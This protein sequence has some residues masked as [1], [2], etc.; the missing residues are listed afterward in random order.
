MSS[1]KH[2]RLP[3]PRTPVISAP[4]P[5]R[6]KKIPSADFCVRPAA[7]R[8]PRPLRRKVILRQ[9]TAGASALSPA[10]F[11][12]RK[13]P[14]C[15]L[16]AGWTDHPV[17]R[18]VAGKSGGRIYRAPRSSGIAL[19][20]PEPHAADVRLVDWRDGGAARQQ[21][22]RNLGHHGHAG[23][24]PSGR[25][26]P[27]RSSGKCAVGRLVARWVQFSGGSRLWR[28]EPPGISNWKAAIPNRRM[29][30]TSPHFSQGRPH[31]VR[32]PSAARRRQWRLGRCG[33]VGQG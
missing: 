30:R 6:A 14:L 8:G 19:H 4:T 7:G 31:R 24:R 26:R 33:Y 12:P 32:R 17:Q 2:R 20:G 11:P 21:S 29:D 13:H 3:L 5:Q 22:H 28:N 1:Q 9:R 16:C 18:G 23:S 27:A 15:P 10:D 25:R